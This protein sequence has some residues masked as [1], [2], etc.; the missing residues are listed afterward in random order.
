MKSDKRGADRGKA[1]PQ[2][3]NRN[4]SGSEGW[5]SSQQG[6]K[7]VW[8]NYQTMLKNSWDG[9]TRTQQEDLI[10]KFAMIITIGVTCL[11]ILIFY[12]VIPRLLRVLGLPVALLG[13]WWAG[14]RIVGPVVI[15]RL[16]NILKDDDRWDD[17]VLREDR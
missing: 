2:A 17:E 5:K 4:L 3:G 12:P 15:D 11:V 13:A 1:P 6:V 14:K 7:R 8:T 10:D 9:M 16:S